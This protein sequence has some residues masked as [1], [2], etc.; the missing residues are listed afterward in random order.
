MQPDQKIMPR[1]RARSVVSATFR[2]LLGWIADNLGGRVPLIIG[3][4]ASITAAIIGYLIY[5]SFHQSDTPIAV[6]N[7]IT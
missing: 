7:S 2:P 5:R 4:I 1:K 6:P 3:G